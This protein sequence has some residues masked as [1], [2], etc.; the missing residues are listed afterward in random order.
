[1]HDDDDVIES[2]TRVHL[3][4]TGMDASVEQ[5]THQEPKR[6]LPCV[7]NKAWS[8]STAIVLSY[9]TYDTHMPGYWT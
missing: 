5:H 7:Q 9:A 2:R 3:R 8:P 6:G 1:M 4:R